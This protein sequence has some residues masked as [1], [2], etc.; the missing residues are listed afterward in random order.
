[1]DS[2]LLCLGCLLWLAPGLHAR[3]D[4]SS[5]S[6]D[7]CIVGAGPAGLQL[8]YF[9]QQSGRDYVIFEQSATSGNFFITYPRHRKLISVNK[10]HTGQL[11]KGFSFRHDWNSLI[12]EDE[13]LLMKH[14]TKEIFPPADIL[15]KYLQ[16]FQRKLGINVQFNTQIKNIRKVD[17]KDGGFLMDDQ[18]EVT[19]SCKRVI[20]ATGMWKPNIPDVR[21]IERAV[22]YES[23]STDPELYEN[24]SV[25]ILGMGNSAMETA[26]SIYSRTQYVHIISR[27]QTVDLAWSTHYVGDLRSVNNNLLDTYLLKSLDGI[28]LLDMQD[29]SIQ[30]RGGKFFVVVDKHYHSNSKSEDSVPDNFPL[31]SGYDMVIRCMGFTFDSSIFNGTSITRPVGKAKKYPA[32]TH[33]YESVDLPG[34]FVAGTATHSLDFRKSAGGFIHGFRYTTQALHRLLEWR[35]E[36]VTWPSATYPLHQLLNVIIKRLNEG[37]GFYQMYGILGDVALIDRARDLVT[38]L[39]EFPINLLPQLTRMTGHNATEVIV[40]ILDYGAP[41]ISSQKFD[42]KASQAHQ[43]YF[44]HPILFYYKQLPTEEDFLLKHQY[45]RLPRPDSLHHIVEDFLVLWQSQNEHVTPVRRWLESV[46]NRSLRSYFSERC[47][48]MAMTYADVPE[49]CDKNYNLGQGLLGAPELL[50]SFQNNRV[51]IPS[52]H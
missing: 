16:D 26:D 41:D 49:S 20:A 52:L 35:Y 13:S 9:M 40:T 24:K 45:D 32:I 19:Y 8:G 25:L 43:S 7:Y 27:K 6:R 33:A 36:G 39:E 22:G 44:L 17:N 34:L 1:M 5:G 46:L 30:E 11:N 12:S 47:F 23:I 28:T 15:V 10:R 42:A 4:N 37:S 29:A 31:R 50:S 2:R 3:V 51:V 18:N 14:Y 48:E 38:Y 21:G